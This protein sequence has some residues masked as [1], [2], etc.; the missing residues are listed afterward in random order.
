MLK[1]TNLNVK[2]KIKYIYRE[3]NSSNTEEYQNIYMNTKKIAKSEKPH[4]LVLASCFQ[5]SKT[6][7]IKHNSFGIAYRTKTTDSHPYQ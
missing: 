4:G 2:N 1:Y 3:N 5:N 6:E 7:N